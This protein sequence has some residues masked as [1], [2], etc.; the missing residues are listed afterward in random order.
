MGAMGRATRRAG[1]DAIELKP[2]EGRC[3]KRLMKPDC[4]LHRIG[5][6]SQILVRAH[7]L[8]GRLWSR[9]MS[10]EKPVPHPDEQCR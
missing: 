10:S 9:S 2:L 3:L 5:E 8:N 4:W 6:T 1:I 7:A